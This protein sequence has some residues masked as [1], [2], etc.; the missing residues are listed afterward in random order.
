[1]IAI[2]AGLPRATL[3]VELEWSYNNIISPRAEV[4]GLSD[5]DEEKGMYQS[6]FRDSR[7][8]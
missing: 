7:T 8:V 3:W 4:I 6:K 1:M 5:L 2:S